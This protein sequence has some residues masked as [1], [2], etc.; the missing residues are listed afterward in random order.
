MNQYLIQSYDSSTT[1]MIIRRSLANKDITE[2][3]E[4]KDYRLSGQ[5]TWWDGFIWN[6]P[7]TC[8][9]SIPAL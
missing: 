9:S 1:K 2:L 3:C 4:W 5:E 6:D 8:N 7:F